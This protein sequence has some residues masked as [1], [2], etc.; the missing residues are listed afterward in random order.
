MYSVVL[1]SSPHDTVL[2]ISFYLSFPSS[3]FFCGFLQSYMVCLFANS[4]Y[5]H[6]HKFLTLFSLCERSAN[7][8]ADALR[9]VHSL[10]QVS[11]RSSCVS[12]FGVASVCSDCMVRGLFT[13]H[14]E[15]HTSKN[16]AKTLLKYLLLFSLWV[17]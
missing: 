4:I 6:F 3:P 7:C 15:A 17:Q 14:A 12:G 11:A 8:Q 9:Y 13:L 2:Q 5:F 10:I 16:C 1:S